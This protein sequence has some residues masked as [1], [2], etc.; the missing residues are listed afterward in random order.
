MIHVVAIITTLPG[1]RAEVLTAF[2]ANVPA[3]LA[4][5][6]C[7]EYT[8]TVDAAGFPASKGSLGEDTFAVVEKWSSVAAL[9]AHAASAHMAAYAAKTRPLKA[10]RMIHVLEPAG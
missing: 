4:E 7:I 2:L 10:N 3:V 6:G 1:K 9:Q 8:A 5:D